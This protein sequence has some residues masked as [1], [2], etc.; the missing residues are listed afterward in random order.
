MFNTR[1]IL[2]KKNKQTKTFE[3]T[4][5]IWHYRVWQ[6]NQVNFTENKQYKFRNN[7]Q[8]L[9]QIWKAELTIWHIHI[10]VNH[11]NL[12]MHMD[13]NVNLI[14]VL[15]WPCAIQIH[16]SMFPFFIFLSSYFYRKCTKKA[17]PYLV[18]STLL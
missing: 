9:N 10:L 18:K 12:T 15:F 13:W 14:I 2:M 11:F 7:L 17:Q 3:Q 8:F 1:Y 6:V 4:N 5:I 16:I